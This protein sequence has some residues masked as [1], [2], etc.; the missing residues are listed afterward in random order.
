MSSHWPTQ[1]VFR[2]LGGE[3]SPSVWWS[4]AGT[5]LAKSADT[6]HRTAGGVRLIQTKQQS[7]GQNPHLLRW[8]AEREPHDVRSVVAPPVPTSFAPPVAGGSV[9]LALLDKWLVGPSGMP[10]ERSK[11][12]GVT[13]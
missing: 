2:A 5:S 12:E 1:R 6:G 4:L 9:R 7:N 13:L 11:I 3:G 10:H 8:S